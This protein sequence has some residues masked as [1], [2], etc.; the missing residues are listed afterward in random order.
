MILFKLGVLSFS[1]VI[2][3]IF[4][5]VLQGTVDLKAVRLDFIGRLNEAITS[6]VS[7]LKCI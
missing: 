3:D 6:G 4:D 2:F 1:L 5:N 7:K